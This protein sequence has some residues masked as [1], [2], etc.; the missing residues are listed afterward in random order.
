MYNI[1]STGIFAQCTL[2]QG[3]QDPPLY[4]VPPSLLVC[5]QD[6]FHYNYDPHQKYLTQA[7]CFP[8]PSV[9]KKKKNVRP[10]FLLH[11]FIEDNLKMCCYAMER[12][13]GPP[14]FATT[15]FSL[16]AEENIFFRFL[17]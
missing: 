9:E 15:P 3:R 2:G 10:F 7:V 8:L 11:N 12:Y 5:M 14:D 4:W 13:V 1:Q 6:L 17:W 16:S